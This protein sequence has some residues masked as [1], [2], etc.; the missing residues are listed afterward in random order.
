MQIIHVDNLESFFVECPFVEGTHSLWLWLY[1]GKL[2][3]CEWEGKS[4]SSVSCAWMAEGI[5][6]GI[7]N[8]IICVYFCLIVGDWVLSIVYFTWGALG[9]ELEEL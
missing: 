9:V 2:I 8:V 1:N 5:R 4:C 6:K 3:I 7:K